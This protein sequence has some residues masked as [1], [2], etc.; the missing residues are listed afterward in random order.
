MSGANGLSIAGPLIN[1]NAIHLSQ[2]P[3]YDRVDA[4]CARCRVSSSSPIVRMPSIRIGRV[5]RLR[6]T[7]AGAQTMDVICTLWPDTE[8]VLQPNEI[9]IDDTVIIGQRISWS[10]AF[11]KVGSKINLLK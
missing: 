1:F 9:V 5:V 6:L 7:I 4:G 10:Q 2:L 3:N 8:N 11:C